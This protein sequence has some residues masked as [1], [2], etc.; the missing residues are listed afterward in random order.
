MQYNV[1][2]Y[3][4][5]LIIYSC[6]LAIMSIIT[7]ISYG[8]DKRK[9]TKKAYRTPE[10]VLLALS[11]FGGAVGGILGMGIFR[12]KTQKKY[13]ALTNILGLLWQTALFVFIAYKL[14]TSI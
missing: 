7:F 10:K 12:H 6:F 1:I 3:K 9:A 2:M 13:F 14:K 4:L 11:F 5:T 8:A